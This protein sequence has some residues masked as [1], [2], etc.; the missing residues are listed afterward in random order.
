MARVATN[1]NRL[2]IIEKYIMLELQR[3]PLKTYFELV[4]LRKDPHL[5]IEEKIEIDFL[6]E[7]AR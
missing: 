4:K 7:E 2:K 6:I 5:S 3:L 1:S